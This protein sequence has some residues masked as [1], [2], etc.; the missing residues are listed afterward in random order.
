MASAV[1]SCG[2]VNENAVEEMCFKQHYINQVGSMQENC[3]KSII[4]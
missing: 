4:Q 3:E 2:G 1:S